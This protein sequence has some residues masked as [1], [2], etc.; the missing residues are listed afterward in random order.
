MK[1]NE[2]IVYRIDTKNDEVTKWYVYGIENI[3]NKWYVIVID[4][5]KNKYEYKLEKIQFN[6][7]GKYAFSNKKEAEKALEENKKYREY[8]VIYNCSHEGTVRLKGNPYK[9]QLALEKI[10]SDICPLCRNKQSEEKGLI[11]REMPY[12]QYKKEYSNCDV[13]V[14]SYRE[15][16]GEKRITVYVEN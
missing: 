3:D 6:H 11:P 8:Y 13:K 9:V 12:Y 5:P 16:N 4:K 7:F 1:S 14:G 15:V 10:Q 2:N